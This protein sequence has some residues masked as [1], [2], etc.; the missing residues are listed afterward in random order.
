MKSVELL[1]TF[2]GE[3]QAVIA[4]GIIRL[5]ERECQA[6]EALSNLRS[7]GPD[8]VLGI[9]KSKNRR[10]GYDK[11]NPMHQAMN[12]LFILSDQN[13]VFIANQVIEL[14]NFIYEYLK[15][16]RMY[17][18]SARLEEVSELIRLYLEAGTVEAHQM[19]EDIRKRL[20]LLGAAKTE[21]P[22]ENIAQNVQGLKVQ[23]D[24]K[25]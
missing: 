16:C 20:Q 23:E 15:I 22:G 4:E 17:Q 25:S 5:A 6:N 21:I 13:R 2:P 18:V 8:K 7:L 24:R 14:V 10:R 12:Y 1:E 9:F 3:I 19:L 11:N